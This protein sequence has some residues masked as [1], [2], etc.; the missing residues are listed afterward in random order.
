MPYLV[1]GAGLGLRRDFLRPLRTEAAV[2]DFIEVAPE[3]WIGVGG[4]LGHA[5]EQASER[6]PLL[7]HGLCLSLGGPDPLDW[8]FLSQAKAFFKR[9]QVRLYSEHL[10]YSSVAGHLYD[11][12]P[13]PFTSAAVS[14]LIQRIQQ[15]QDFLG[16]QIA[17]EN[18]SYYAAPG[19]EMSEIEFL[20]QILQGAD[21]QLLLDVNNL[22]VNSINH[23]YRAEDFLQQIPPERIA[24]AHI[25]GH[26]PQ[27]QRLLVDTHGTPVSPAVWALL[28]QVYQQFGPLPT[29]LER[30][31]NLPPLTELYDEVR[32]IQA[33]QQEYR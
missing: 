20:L 19:A 30:D 15:V 1:N 10:S 17:I 7:C 13:I 32:Q 24:Y 16:Q 28:E 27:H 33:R 25:A 31:F 29:L 14:Y 26:L 18:V 11:L 23:D 22:Y 3:N 5:L 21:C 4:A 2:A 6:Y 9:H 12:L 8:Q